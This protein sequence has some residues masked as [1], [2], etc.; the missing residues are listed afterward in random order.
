MG[1]MDIVSQ[2]GLET[3]VDEEYSCCNFALEEEI[4]FGNLV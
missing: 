1:L 4:Q 3:I 2:D